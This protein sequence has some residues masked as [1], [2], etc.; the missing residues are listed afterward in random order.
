MSKRVWLSRLC[1]VLGQHRFHHTS[2]LG[3][4][5][6]EALAVCYT[7]INQSSCSQCK[8]QLPGFMV[9]MQPVPEMLTLFSLVTSP[10]TQSAYCVLSGCR[11][12][13]YLS[14]HLAGQHPQQN[15]TGL[16]MY[17]GPGF[18]EELLVRTHFLAKMSMIQHPSLISGIHHH[19][20]QTVKVFPTHK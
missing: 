6:C 3:L 18:Q 10:F 7:F 15:K 20:C 16:Q 2:L 19:T 17:K 4:R 11:C 13:N 8:D 14:M 5:V 12:G 9:L 1:P